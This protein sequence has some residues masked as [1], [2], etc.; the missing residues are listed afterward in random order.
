[1]KPFAF[2]A[3]PELP[4]VQITP[5]MVE[6]LDTL[7]RCGDTPSPDDEADEERGELVW[8]KGAGWWLGNHRVSSTACKRLLQACALRG[9]S[10]NHIGKYEVYTINETGRKILSLSAGRSAQPHD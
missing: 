10:F 3:H 8:E 9:A 2:T 1:M 5:R 7:R 4:V 6:L